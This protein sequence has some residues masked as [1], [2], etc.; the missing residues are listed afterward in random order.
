M[1]AFL[2]PT[3]WALGM[4]LIGT[5]VFALIG[6]V[7]GT[8]ETATIAPLTLLVILLGV[9][10]AGVFAFFMAAIAAKHITHAIPTTLLVLQSRLWRVS[11]A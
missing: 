11:A 8:D 4:A 2:E 9:P 3:M 6:L 7:S 1:E 10:P 5:V